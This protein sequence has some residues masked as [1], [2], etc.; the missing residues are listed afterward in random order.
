[1]LGLPLGI[2]I[3][4]ISGIAV[5]LMLRT[6]TRVIVDLRALA[7]LVAELLAVPT[8]WFG[9]PWV[10]TAMLQGVRLDEILSFYMASPAVTFVF[11]SGWPLLRL[12]ARIG[13][14]I[15]NEAP[16]PT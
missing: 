8:F 6:A 2:L 13:R 14:E 10:A 3:G 1:M 12:I 16:Q 7:T 15:A 9:G 4:V 5:L 11:I